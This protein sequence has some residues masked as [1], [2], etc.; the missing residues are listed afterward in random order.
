M[1]GS[2]LWIETNNEIIIA[3][4]SLFFYFQILFGSCIGGKIV[5]FNDKIL[6]EKDQN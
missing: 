4:K 3:F 6:N 5:S 1:K 2:K